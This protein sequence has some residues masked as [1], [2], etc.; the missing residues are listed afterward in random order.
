MLVGVDIPTLGCWEIRGRY[1]EA[2]LSFVVWVGPAQVAPLP[3]YTSDLE[4]LKLIAMGEQAGQIAQK[5]GADLVLRQVDTDLSFTDFQFVDAAL[6][7]VVTVIVPRRDDPVDG[8]YTTVYAVSPLLS[9][10]E[11]AL[12]L[13]ISGTA[14][15]G[16]RRPL[17]RSGLGAHCAESCCTAKTNSPPG[18][19][20]A[21]HQKGSCR[22]AW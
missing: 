22:E 7:R 9:H 21:I 14:P 11:P 6:T 1:A 2:E 8:W 12:D 19:L 20:S 4:A 3:N 15:N 17:Q 5:E 10:A 16:W 18:W 13:V